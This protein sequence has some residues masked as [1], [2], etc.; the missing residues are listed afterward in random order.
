MELSTFCQ[1]T[2]KK[3]GLFPRRDAQPEPLGDTQEGAPATPGI[4]ASEQNR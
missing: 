1:K 3:A 4:F 2:V